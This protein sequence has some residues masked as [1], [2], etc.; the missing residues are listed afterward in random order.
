MRHPL[1]TVEYEG[2]DGKSALQAKFDAQKIAFAPIVF[3]A[4]KS[5]LELGILEEV[6]QHRNAGISA[7]AIAE[8]LDLPEYGVQVL[9]EVGLSSDLVFI[10]EDRFSITKTGYFLLKDEMTRVNLNFVDK[11][12]YQGMS[13][14]SEAIREQKPAGLAALGEWNTIYEGLSSLPED[15]QQSWFEFDH[16]YSDV[17][18]P[19]VAPIVFADKP[20]HMLDIGGNT[21]KWAMFCAE[22]NPDVR[23]TMVDLPGQLEQARANIEA[24]GHA[25]RVAYHPTNLLLDDSPLPEGADIIWM[26]QFLDCFSPEEITN[27]LC[28]VKTAMTEHATVHILE[29]LWDLQ[30]F[31]AAAFTLHNT[32]LY[33][34]CLANGNSKMYHSDELK[35]CIDAAGLAVVDQV[36]DIGM[37][38]T[39]LSCKLPD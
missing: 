35:A 32:S 4:S 27:I 39:L 18:F 21:G 8:K 22:H 38:H 30:R 10:T 11:V 12:C 36:D 9:L 2:P 19:E 37:G 29:T 14:L 17:A 1:K 3:Q 20:K 23:I 6:F 15:V 25:A 16:Y 28:R 26:S 13:S 7:A 24:A 34:T 31:E 33:F 5:L